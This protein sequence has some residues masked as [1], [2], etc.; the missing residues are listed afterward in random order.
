M[1]ER[2]GD[3]VRFQNFT[4]VES[5]A[6]LNSGLIGGAIVTVL[7]AAAA[8]SHSKPVISTP[9]FG[10]AVDTNSWFLV[11]QRGYYVKIRT[12]VW[13]V[14][15]EVPLDSEGVLTNRQ[16]DMGIVGTILPREIYVPGFRIMPIQG[17]S[18]ILT[19]QSLKNR[20]HIITITDF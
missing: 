17:S 18:N 15:L 11:N 7:T 6:I 8:I 2:E 5:V 10:T 20:G 14:K 12:N 9:T 16:S 1:D 4:T 13:P 19:I 3:A